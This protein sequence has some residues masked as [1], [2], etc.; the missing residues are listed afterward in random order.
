MEVIYDFKRSKKHLTL[1]VLK[2]HLRT[3]THRRTGDVLFKGGTESLRRLLYKLGFNYVLD[4]G[5]YYIREN[6]RIQLLRTQY[7]LRFHANYISPDKLDEKYQDETWVYMGGTGQRV[8]GWI[9]KDVRS[10]SRRTTSLGDRSTI[11]HVGGRKGWVEGAL[12]FLAPHKDSK[13]DYHK[14]MNRDE[15]LRHFRE[16]ILPNMTEPSLLIMDNASYHRMQVKN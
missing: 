11:S 7:L 14:S 8:R 13:E 12:M 5:T 15:F 2:E 10:F 3:V 6:P 4:N 9:N 1:R 16:D